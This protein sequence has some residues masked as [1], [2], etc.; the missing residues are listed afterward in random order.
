MKF[1]QLH[2]FYHKILGGTKV[3]L[4]STVQKLVGRV[5]PYPLKLGPCAEQ[6]KLPE[7]SSVDLV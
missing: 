1:V 3:I 4:S 5:S 7:M 6:L 2:Y